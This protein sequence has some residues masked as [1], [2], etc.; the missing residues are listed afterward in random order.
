MGA[1]DDGITGGQNAIDKETLAPR[2]RGVQAAYGNK[3]ATHD[4]GSSEPVACLFWS[5][6]NLQSYLNI[7]TV[8][9]YNP[10]GKNRRLG[11]WIFVGIWEGYDLVV[12]FTITRSSIDEVPSTDLQRAAVFKAQFEKLINRVDLSVGKVD[13]L[14]LDKHRAHQLERN[15]AAHLDTCSG[16]C[17]QLAIR[18]SVLSFHF[19]VEEECH[20]R[21]RSRISNLGPGRSSALGPGFG[22][23]L[24]LGPRF[25]PGFGLACRCSYPNSCSNWSCYWNSRC[26]LH[27]QLRFRLRFRLPPSSH[28]RFR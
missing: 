2:H 7:E 13:N 25:A 17:R 26:R 15:A 20:R 22:R 21:S 10:F 19:L 6:S 5:L 16:F 23:L 9:D 24:V 4:S 18:P 3:S 8:P 27:S 12:Y 28:C 1:E 14:S 11:R